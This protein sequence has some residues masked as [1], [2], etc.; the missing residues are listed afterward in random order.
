MFQFYDSPIKRI[1]W[2]R[3]NIGATSFNSMI[4]RLKACLP[5]FH[6]TILSCFNSMIVRLKVP[7]GA[8]MF[9]YI[10]RFQFYDSPIKS[11]FYPFHVNK[12]PMFQFYDSPIKSSN[13]SQ[14]LAEKQRFQ[15]YDSP[16][17]S[18]NPSCI[19]PV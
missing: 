19:I 1:V 12:S 13:S 14:F 7:A 3:C 6:D 8:C 9:V 16:I 11:G 5:S 10:V 18:S 2:E 4:V 15:F 17:K